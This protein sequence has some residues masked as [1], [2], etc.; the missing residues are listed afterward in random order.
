M[1][2]LAASPAH[3]A[4]DCGSYFVTCQVQVDDSGRVWFTS[5]ELLTEDA[6]GDGTPRHGVLQVFERNGDRTTLIEGPDGKPIPY[7]EQHRYSE[8]LN[9]VSPDGERV[10]ISTEASLTPD[11]HDAPPYSDSSVDSYELAGGKYTL[12]T[13]GPLEE[14]APS[15]F[16]NGAHIAWAS[17]DGRYVYFTTDLRMTAEDH[18]ATTDVYQRSEG[19]TRLVST[20]PAETVPDPNSNE[21]VPQA[22][23][24]GASTD[25]ATAYFS[26]SQQLTAD[27]TEKLTS[28]IFSWH[29]GVTRRLTHTLRYP[30]GPGSTWEIFE[31]GSFA[32]AASD[33][34]IF[35]LAHQPQTPDD[36][37][38]Y[39]DLYRTFADGTTERLTANLPPLDPT[40]DATQSFLRPGAVSHDGSRLFFFTNRPLLPEDTDNTLDIYLLET[41]TGRLR[42]VSQG[43]AEN[44][45][46]DAEL[47]LSGISRDGSRAFFSTWE[48]LSP[49]DTDQEVDVYEWND[50]RTRLATPASDGRQTHAF[51]KSISPNGRYV[52]FETFEDLLPGDG[53]NHNDLYL[54]DMGPDNVTPSDSLARAARSGGKHPHRRQLR[55]VSAESIPPRMRIAAGGTFGNGKAH[56]EIGCPK[57]ETSGPC[58]GRAKLIDPRTHAVLA[59]GKF[60]IGSGHHARVELDGRA[61]WRLGRSL[62]AIARVRGADRL[63]NA[64]RVQATVVLRHTP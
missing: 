28:D 64:A 48:Q 40:A 18:D 15:P 50:G 16:A 61:L 58:H 51:F 46:K 60:R 56:L 17:D 23:F 34:S 39:E 36:T 31:R 43:T 44:P 37:N 27:D 7:S 32:G 55:L 5:D 14:S 3:A 49:E 38:T 6:L 10:Y 59:S 21:F 22:N 63:H 9:G 53:D 57:A 2:L 25:G 41:A 52:V 33:G 29:D 4:F 1:A 30:E 12:L 47:T 19:H 13:T 62:S 20:G 26:T 24:L 35:Y 45:P 11:D 54:V 8:Y 42:L